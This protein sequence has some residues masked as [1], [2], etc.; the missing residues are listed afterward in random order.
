MSVDCNSTFASNISE[1]YRCS[2][3]PPATW[4][5]SSMLCYCHNFQHIHTYNNSNNEKNKNLLRGCNLLEWTVN[6]WRSK[7]SKFYNIFLFLKLFVCMQHIHTRQVTVINVPGNLI[8]WKKKQS[9]KVKRKLKVTIKNKLWKENMKQ[10]DRYWSIASV[11]WPPYYIAQT[12]ANY[13]IN[14][15]KYI[16][17]EQVSN[18]LITSL[19]FF[20][21]NYR[22]VMS[23]SL[24]FGSKLQITEELSTFISKITSL[25]GHI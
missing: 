10:V 21:W 16:Q 19:P 24:W 2:F 13:F 12:E 7:F 17:P 5:H 8:R 6:C 14:I 4:Y 1:I 11:F 22:I 20:Y 3:F 23:G 9:R 25:S 15:W 18:S